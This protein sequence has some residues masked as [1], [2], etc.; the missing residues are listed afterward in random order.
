MIRSSI[1]RIGRRCFSSEAVVITTPIF[2]V[3]AK[4]HIGH[5]YSMTLADVYNR[6]LKLSGESTFFTTGTDEHGLKVQTAAAVA[7]MDPKTFCDGLSQKFRELASVGNI[8]YDRFIRT[9]DPDHLEAVQFFWRT[10]E[11]KGHIYK[12]KHCGWYSVSDECFYAETEIEE[13]DGKMVA[14]E[15]GATVVHET[16]ENYFFRLS[17]HQ[18]RL[19][20]FLEDNP[21][22]V[23]P[24][25]YYHALLRDLKSRDLEDLSVSRPSSRVSWG[26]SVPNDPSQKMYV[27]FDALVNYLTCIGYPSQIPQQPSFVH[28][29][30]KEIV[31]FHCIHWPSFLMACELPLPRGV[32]VHGHWL[33]DGRKMSKSRGNVADPLEI[34]EKYDTD[35]L[36]LFMMRYSVLDSDCDYSER[37]LN[38]TRN[39]FI[40]K[41]CNLLTRSLTK[42]FSISRALAKVETR[43]LASLLD[44]A[45]EELSSD[46]R[47]LF[48]Q[49]DELPATI[50]PHLRK[51]ELHKAVLAI[52]Q[53]LP[54]IN[55]LFDQYEPWRLKGPD[56]ELLQDLV[57]FSALDSLRCL[58]ILLQPVVPDYTKML[59]DKLQVEPS[60]RTLDMAG[61]ARDTSYAKS[62]TFSKGEKVPLQKIK[63]D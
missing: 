39:E 14:K 4:P 5:Y 18:Q 57:I 22:F 55:G 31:K 50:D 35:A 9:T 19:V 26:V 43:G 56:N 2:Y 15:T 36:R 60:K 23:Q 52:W 58:L 32:F 41:F 1:L 44:D 54:R 49:V 61:I 38:A 8:H 51:M 53:L 48:E 34:S 7:G 62:A 11:E 28:L 21:S 63:L 10:L 13:V 6:W 40:D 12:G 47:S 25:V 42:K 16:E 3:N 30:G 59:L 37:K 29:V 46:L 45:G 27:W 24:P 33:M 20:Q 17:E